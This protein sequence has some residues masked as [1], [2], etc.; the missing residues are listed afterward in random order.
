MCNAWNHPDDCTCGFGGEGHL[1]RGGGGFGGGW[2]RFHRQPPEVDWAWRD[3]Y[4][5]PTTCPRC[6][7]RVYFVRH[8]GGCVWLDELG[9]PWPKHEC[10]D[11]RPEPRWSA[12]LRRLMDQRRRP[13]V[14]GTPD[15]ERSVTGI[16]IEAR[17]LKGQDP[18]EDELTVNFGREGVWVLRA[19]SNGGAFFVGEIVVFLL[20]SRTLIFSNGQVRTILGGQRRRF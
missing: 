7:E 19:E 12:D 10:F 16:V 6:G 17:R 9:W 4:A 20:E 2:W 18:V 11:D 15:S 14:E 8:N 1:G 3:S 5:A 13:V